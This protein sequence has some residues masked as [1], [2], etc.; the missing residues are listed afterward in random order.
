MWPFSRKK[1]DKVPPAPISVTAALDRLASLGIRLRAGISND[2][3]LF[4]LGGTLES[5]VEW[6]DLL[7]VLGSEVER[8]DF[9]PMSDDIWHLD[10]E[11]IVED[12]DYAELLNRFVVLAKGALPLTGVRDH[13]DLEAEEAW[14][15]FSLDGKGMHWDLQVSDDWVDAELYSRLQQLVSTRGAGKRFFIAGLG[16]DSLISFGTD[17]MRLILSTLSGLEFAWE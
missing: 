17:Q 10:A 6:V 1:L 3:L 8:G 4:S 14:V 13:V 7:C 2:D 5:P 12:G 9:E 11:C 15:E 16:Q